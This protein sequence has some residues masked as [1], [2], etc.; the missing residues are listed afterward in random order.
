MLGRVDAGTSTPATTSSEWLF[1][2]LSSG[3]NSFCVFSADCA[4]FTYMNNSQFALQSTPM[5]RFQFVTWL[6]QHA[7]NLIGV[8]ARVMEAPIGIKIQSDWRC[9]GQFHA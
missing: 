2:T 3:C 6:L 7:G 8:N 4:N 9:I 5:H 1:H